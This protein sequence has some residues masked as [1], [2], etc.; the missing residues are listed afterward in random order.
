[1]SSLADERDV[2]KVLLGP[3]VLQGGQDA[4]LEV[5]PPE[6]ELLVAGTH[7]FGGWGGGVWGSV[8][9]PQRLQVNL[10]KGGDSSFGPGDLVD[11][12]RRRGVS[13]GVPPRLA[14]GARLSVHVEDA[15]A[16]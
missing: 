15:L 13:P 6:A 10:G 3:Q 5:V 8:S 14:A 4:L 16:L 1:M 7:F 9:C 12:R 2:H 11:G